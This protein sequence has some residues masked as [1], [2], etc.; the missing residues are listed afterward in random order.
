M[1]EVLTRPFRRRAEREAAKLP[2][3]IEADPSLVLKPPRHYHVCLTTYHGV[4]K[5]GKFTFATNFDLIAND[6]ALAKS[7]AMRL[8]RRLNVHLNELH[9][10]AERACVG[11]DD[12]EH[13]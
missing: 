13:S 2:P 5:D 8:S 10:C 12:A 9:E 11:T 3:E 4:D 7:R 6:V 1:L